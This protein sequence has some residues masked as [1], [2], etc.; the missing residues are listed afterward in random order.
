MEGGNSNKL[1]YNSR[2]SHRAYPNGDI[3]ESFSL[4]KSSLTL[5]GFKALLRVFFTASSSLDENECVRRRSKA[6]SCRFLAARSSGVL[7]CRSVTLESAFFS[8]RNVMS[9]SSPFSAAT[10]RGVCFL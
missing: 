9:S 6:V 7:P 2:S 1:L 8:R 4:T 10:S 3:T 5:S